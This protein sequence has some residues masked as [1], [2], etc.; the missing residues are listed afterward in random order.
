MLCLASL[1]ST[2]SY[3]EIFTERLYLHHQEFLLLGTYISGALDLSDPS[4]ARRF[5]DYSYK[6]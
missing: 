3:E 5:G 2:I 4:F 6:W 1:W